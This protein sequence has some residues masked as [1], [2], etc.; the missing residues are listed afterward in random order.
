MIF[1]FVIVYQTENQFFPFLDQLNFYL[2]Y[3]RYFRNININNVFEM[4][5]AIQPNVT[6]IKTFNFRIIF[7]FNKFF[8]IFNLHFTKLKWEP[9]V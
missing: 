7:K 1:L 8:R 5:E 3:L 2:T 4:N 6:R 9:D